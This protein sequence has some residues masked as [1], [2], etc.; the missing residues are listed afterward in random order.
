M[1]LIPV[2]GT[3]LERFASLLDVHWIGLFVSIGT[4]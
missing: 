2:F 1:A 3:A 4:A